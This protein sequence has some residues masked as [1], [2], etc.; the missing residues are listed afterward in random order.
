MHRC[1]SVL[2]LALA[3]TFVLSTLGGENAVL[4][5]EPNISLMKASSVHFRSAMVTFRSRQKPSNW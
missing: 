5:E 3:I 1:G 4:A 2:L